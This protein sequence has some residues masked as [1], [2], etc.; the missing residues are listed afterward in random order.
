MGRVMSWIVKEGDRVLVPPVAGRVNSATVKEVVGVVGA[1]AGKLS[2][3]VVVDGCS[4][5]EMFY[6]D[7]LTKMEQQ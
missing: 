5:S 7:Q 4:I 3:I 1:V 6:F 2:V